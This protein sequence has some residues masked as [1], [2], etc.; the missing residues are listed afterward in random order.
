MTRTAMNLPMKTVALALWAT[1]GCYSGFG[2][3]AD[4]DG[5]S[6]AP[7]ADGGASGEDG[8]PPGD[9]DGGHSGPCPSAAPAS[10]Q[11]NYG[12]ALQK[13]LFFYEAQR[14]GPLP[15][16]NRVSWR[17][18]A[19]LAD[20][21]DVGEDL[22]GGWFD[23]GDH[24]KFGFPI[25]ASATML[26]WGVVEYRDA[27]Q[28]SCQLGHALANLRWVSDYF[29][30]AHSAPDVLYGQVGAGSD[31]HAWWGPAEVMQMERPAYKVDASC[32]GSDLAGETS[33]ALA[34]ASIAFRPVDP[35]YADELL[36]HAT[37][38]FAFADTHRGKYSDC[39]TD[40]RAFYNSWSGYAD[41][42]AWAAAWLYRATDD[43]AYL[44]RAEAL[45]AALSPDF[46]WTHAWDDKS[47]GTAVLLAQLTAGAATY[48][49]DSQRLLDFWTVGDG[50]SRVTYTPGGLAWL[51]Q[52]GALRYAANT[53]FLALVYSA[54]LSDAE[55]KTRY[56]DFAVA[57]IDY[58]LG[59]NPRA[60]SYVVGF[61]DNPPRNPHHR[62][63]HGSYTNSIQSP[64]LNRHVLYGA[65]VGGPGAD[66]AWS[67]DRGDYVKNEVATDYNAAF[68]GA[69]AGLYQ[70]YGGIPLAAFPPAEVPDGP[71]I[72]VA[73]AVNSTGSNYTEIKAVLS[74]QS[75]WPARIG[76]ALS[77]R[78][79]LTLEEGITAADV[80]VTSGY[81]QCPTPPTLEHDQGQRYYIAI[82]CSGTAI[83]PG[84]QSEHKKE[85]QFRIS[86]AGAWDPDNDWSYA[87]VPADPGAPPQ[88]AAHIPVYEDGV[89]VHGDAP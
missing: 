26:A 34:A 60:G 23:A 47:Y 74:N 70:E 63:A 51:D 9:D 3:D 17:G 61:G 78:Y 49:R 39:I 45:Y 67:D 44:A 69:L 48:Q 6:T 85:I 52:W 55:L 89:L 42:L 18:D 1:A 8:A 86:S 33:A 57:Q 46:R 53:A 7:G 77:F 76:N 16:H 14:A 40:A 25:A 12:E 19:A 72:F 58:I 62:T 84:G 56:H 38:L 82:D 37:T 50:D 32:P 11:F 43:S 66:D 2:A 36:D 35:G 28:Q 80:T 13:S 83:Y 20:G 88:V 41:E 79:Y 27:Y 87:G 54:T 30:R 64:A 5:G 29:I 24:V 71:E 75:A 10:G 65:L 31:D 4:A 81:S 22:S 68:T 73:A 15:A 21:S 59:D